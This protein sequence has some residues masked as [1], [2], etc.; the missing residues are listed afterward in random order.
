MKSERYQFLVR[1]DFD[2][3]YVKGETN[4]AGA[5][6]TGRYYESDH[7]DESRDR[8]PSQCETRM[9]CRPAPG[10]ALGENGSSCPKLR[11]EDTA[12]SRK[13]VNARTGRGLERDD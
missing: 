1:F 5:P 12:R 6:S 2:I 3:T 13:N 8:K 10:I 4:V 9:R 7:W 11:S